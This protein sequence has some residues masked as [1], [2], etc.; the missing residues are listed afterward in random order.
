MAFDGLHNLTP[1]ANYVTITTPSRSNFIFD[2]DL[3]SGH[4]PLAFDKAT[5]TSYELRNFDG[6]LIKS[7]ALVAGAPPTIVDADLTWRGG[8]PR[9]WYRLYLFGTDLGTGWGTAY[10]DVCFY[11]V[12]TDARFPNNPS[13]STAT[14]GNDVDE[15][16]RGVMGLG[17]ARYRGELTQ[18]A[19]YGGVDYQTTSAA[20]SVASAMGATDFGAV[21][22]FF[23]HVFIGDPSELATPTTGGAACTWR[24]ES[25]ATKNTL[26]VSLWT[27]KAVLNG[28]Q[29]PGYCTFSSGTKTGTHHL[30]HFEGVW[31]NLDQNRTAATS[32]G[33]GTSASVTVP[34]QGFT[35]FDQKMVVGIVATASGT[36]FGS[37]PTDYITNGWTPTPSV[38][39]T[40]PNSI[41]SVA[42]NMVFGDA[43]NSLTISWSGSKD[44]VIVGWAVAAQR[45]GAGLPT[46]GVTLAKT[47][48]TN[49]KMANRD[50]KSVVLFADGI[51]NRTGLVSGA[52]T[53]LMPYDVVFEP[54]NEPVF[55]FGPFGTST[56]ISQELAP[57][58]AAAKAADP[59]AKVLGSG[60]VNFNNSGYVNAP[61]HDWLEM[62]CAN[63]GLAYC[64]AISLH[65][66]NSSNG[67]LALTRRS[68]EHVHTLLTAAGAP[69]KEL[70]QTEQGWATFYLGQVWPRYSGRWCALFTFVAELYGIPAER[71]YYWYDRDI[72]FWAFPTYWVTPYGPSPNGLIV[73]TQVAEIGDRTFT[74]QL[75][76]GSAVNLYAG[77]TWAGSDGTKTVGFIASSYGQ[78]TVRFA[79]NA[80]SLVT[81]DC[82]GNTATIAASGGFVIVPSSE[83]GV[84]IRVPNGITCTLVENDWSWGTNA[85]VTGTASTDATSYTNEPVSLVN[86]GFFQNQYDYDQSTLDFF[87][88]APWSNSTIPTTFPKT[89][90]VTF[91]ATRDVERFVVV[92]TPPWQYLTTL[93]DFDIQAQAA[94]NSWST[95]YTYA[96]PTSTSFFFK[97][98]SGCTAETFFNQQS[99]WVYKPTT[100]VTCKAW[101]VVVRSTSW[102]PHESTTHN[103]NGQVGGND[104]AQILMI[105]EMQAF[106]GG[107]G[108]P[109]APGRRRVSRRF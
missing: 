43:A 81:V 36:T 71:N 60:H 47:Y 104:A 96:P 91:T 90:T 29:N 38:Y 64:D 44:Y 58:Y 18:I 40:A 21:T 16:A 100:P 74:A 83:M 31:A 67:D 106:Y 5:A 4:I 93:L 105:S 14:S 8:G 24:L 57:F 88:V 89:V 52:V 2:G 73:R 85:S 10:G 51:H 82:W 66:Y 80:A 19:P 79:T 103:N 87:G 30:Y 63:G 97:S 35:A 54:F 13:P 28:V 101:R 20:T 49:Y 34:V 7:G 15:P 56:Y 59:T 94:D 77:G 6:A 75:D 55:T 41:F 12:A 53:S 11:R 92:C 25:R 86:D 107:A 1:H 98:R 39:P 46:A 84:W 72:G 62:F 22:P 37:W 76:F 108:I 9:G 42:T 32:T 33:T 68:F 3:V 27:A 26:T 69:N 17:A 65:A 78:P 48:C 61:A 70:W 102:G 95:I 99:T 23:V 109:A 45:V 50:R